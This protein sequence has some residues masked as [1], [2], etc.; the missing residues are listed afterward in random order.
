[1]VF[2]LNINVYSRVGS[3]SVHDF[4]SVHDFGT[5]KRMRLHNADFR[6]QNVFGRKIRGKSALHSRILFASTKVMHRPRSDFPL[7]F[8]IENTYQIR[9]EK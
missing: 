1:M 5:Y 9:K 4:A 7:Y 2:V 8:D 3:R 6:F